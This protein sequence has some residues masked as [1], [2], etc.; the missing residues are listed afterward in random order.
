MSRPEARCDFLAI[1]PDGRT[2]AV[3]LSQGGSIY[4]L[5]AATGKKLYQFS[6]RWPFD[7]VAFSP[8]G[9]GLASVGRNPRWG[10]ALDSVPFR[11][12]S[13]SQSVLLLLPLGG[14]RGAVGGR[15]ILH[16]GLPLGRLGDSGP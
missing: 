10:T 3:G 9:T 15:H 8:D 5:D 16:A 2:L 7:M 1:S 4:F 11:E 6:V 12:R 14:S 13:A